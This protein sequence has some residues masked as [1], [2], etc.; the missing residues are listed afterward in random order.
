MKE[1]KLIGTSS[2]PYQENCSIQVLNI[3][4]ITTTKHRRDER[5]YRVPCHELLPEKI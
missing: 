2:I 5:Y 3:K 1:E 4:E